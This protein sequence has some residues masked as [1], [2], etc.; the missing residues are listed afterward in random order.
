ML[1]TQLAYIIAEVTE[2][3]QR[4]VREI[5]TCGNM[6]KLF[7]TI[8]ANPRD[9]MAPVAVETSDPLDRMIDSL[10]GHRTQT[11]Q[12]SLTEVLGK[13]TNLYRL[14]IVKSR[15]RIQKI[16]FGRT[17]EERLQ[18]L[19]N[20]MTEQ[21]RT[22]GAHRDVDNVILLHRLIRTVEDIYTTLPDFFGKQFNLDEAKTARYMACKRLLSHP[23]TIRMLDQRTALVGEQEHRELMALVSDGV[24]AAQQPADAAAS[25]VYN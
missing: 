7:E 21:T 3:A 8:L 1:P 2:E 25:R 14:R 11:G 23:D 18:T 6:V 17:P 12:P 20:T 22:G 16:V 19:V 9:L 13:E 10:C 24:I 5:R 15:Q 4:C